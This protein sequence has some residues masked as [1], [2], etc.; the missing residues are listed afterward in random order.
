MTLVSKL[1]R[2]AETIDATSQEVITQIKQ[3]YYAIKV[4]DLL[5]LFTNIGRRP[6]VVWKQKRWHN[7]EEYW[8]KRD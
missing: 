7:I 4:I 8:R 5:Y 1:K 2:K 3:S 6:R